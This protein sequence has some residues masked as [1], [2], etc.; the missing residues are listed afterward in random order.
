[1]YLNYNYKEFL[2]N[3]HENSPPLP[4]VSHIKFD[5][6]QQTFSSFILYYRF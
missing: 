1:M 5:I 6:D 3:E 2:G 4:P